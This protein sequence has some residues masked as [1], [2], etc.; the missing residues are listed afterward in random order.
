MQW[1]NW[2]EKEENCGGKQRDLGFSKTLENNL[3]LIFRQRFH[4]YKKIH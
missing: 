3:T 2:S 4:L 1:E